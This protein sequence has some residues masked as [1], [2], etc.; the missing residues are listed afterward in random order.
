MRNIKTRLSGNNNFIKINDKRV[1]LFSAKIIY[2]CEQCHALLK[3][4]NA[5]LICTENPKHRGFIHRN[6]VA[7]IQAQQAAN[8]NQLNDFY[9]I[10]NG[11]V[12]I[13]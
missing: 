9:K 8:V 1:D 5:G 11:K 10:V 3:Y 7:R 4:H 6:E 2:R 12:I 13:K